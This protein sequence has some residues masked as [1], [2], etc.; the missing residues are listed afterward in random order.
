MHKRGQSDYDSADVDRIFQSGEIG[1]GQ[2]TAGEKGTG[3]VYLLAS[4]LYRSQVPRDDRQVA[5]PKGS[6]ETERCQRDWEHLQR[7]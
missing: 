3:E 5:L 6:I 7:S 2:C 4:M 1:S